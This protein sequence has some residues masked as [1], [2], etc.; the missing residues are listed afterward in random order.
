MSVSNA[1]GTSTQQYRVQSHN[2]R[3]PD[4]AVEG[5][6]WLG[7]VR[8]MMSR[9]WDAKVS[10]KALGHD[11]SI[12]RKVLFTRYGVTH[13]FLK[14]MISISQRIQRRSV[15]SSIHWAVLMASVK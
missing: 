8:K 9:I 15:F 5:L 1:V 10:T 14:L 13:E 6:M 7:Y 3:I 12:Q 11:I 2:L 4:S